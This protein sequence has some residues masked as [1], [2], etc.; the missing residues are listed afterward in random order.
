MSTLKFDLETRLFETDP[1]ELANTAT[2]GLGFAL[3]VPAAAVMLGTAWNQGEIWHITGC[4]I[5][6]VCLV[7]VYAASTLSHMFRAP[8]LRRTFRILDQGTIYLLIAGTY[9]P[10]GLVYLRDG[11]WPSVLA[12]M[13]GVA[14]Y[15]F[16]SKVWFEHRVDAVSATLCLAL[17]WLPIV[18]VPALVDRVPL[19][20]LL[21][22]LAGGI[23]YTVGLIF[24]HIDR[25]LPYAHAAWHI[26]VIAGSAC[27]YVGIFYY[28]IPWQS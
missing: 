19:S 11:W 18:C 14:L 5:Y 17:G 3:A 7:A 1:Q 23:C 24:W 22:M 13:W 21:W 16:F 20:A 4:A 9:T 28:A 27:H 12:V 10:F 26:L 2:H 6:A 8:H 25:R 15:G